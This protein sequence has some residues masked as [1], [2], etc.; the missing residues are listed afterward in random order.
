MQYQH[1]CSSCNQLF[2]SPNRYHARCPHHPYSAS[3][4]VVD[5][6]E[7]ALDAYIAVAAIDVA[8]DL[9]GGAASAFGSLFD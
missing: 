7:A 1:R 8:S 9:L 3:N 4:F 2:V 6:A 5:V